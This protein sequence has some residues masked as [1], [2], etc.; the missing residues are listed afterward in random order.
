[1]FVKTNCRVI[2]AT[3][4]TTGTTVAVITQYSAVL[5]LSLYMNGG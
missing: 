2:T 1:M 3:V 4:L 5:T